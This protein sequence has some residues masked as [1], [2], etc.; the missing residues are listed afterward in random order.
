MPLYRGLVE[1]GR[2]AL[3]E[4]TIYCSHCHLPADRSETVGESGAMAYELICPEANA[5]RAGA[6]RIVLGTWVNEEERSADI[7]NFL[8]PIGQPH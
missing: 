4:I 8:H 3:N 2:T 7:R 5:A 1:C 6:H